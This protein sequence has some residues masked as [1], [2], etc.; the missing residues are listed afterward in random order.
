M[1]IESSCDVYIEYNSLQDLTLWWG[2]LAGNPGVIVFPFRCLDKARKE[3][4]RNH[5]L[6]PFTSTAD[7]PY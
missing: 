1:D 3:P 5:H 4:H 2:S 6:L 7:L